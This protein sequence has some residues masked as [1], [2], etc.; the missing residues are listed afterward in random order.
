MHRPCTI[1]AM[2]MKAIPML[3]S[4]PTRRYTQYRLITRLL[5]PHNAISAFI[6][7]PLLREETAKVVALRT[8]TIHDN[9]SKTVRR[10]CSSSSRDDDEDDDDDL[11]SNLIR[12]E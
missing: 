4:L 3:S 8:I 10:H 6:S 12:I 11:T 7:D 9:T 2:Q 5:I 1:C